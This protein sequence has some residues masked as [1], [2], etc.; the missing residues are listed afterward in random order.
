MRNE[1][2][3]CDKQLMEN[4][5]KFVSKYLLISILVFKSQIFEIPVWPRRL[6]GDTCL[7]NFFKYYALE[8]DLFQKKITGRLLASLF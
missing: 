3:N 7:I 2:A 5:F 8:I 1:N 4:A 6:L